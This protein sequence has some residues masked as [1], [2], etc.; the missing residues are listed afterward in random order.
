MKNKILLIALILLAFLSCKKDDPGPSYSLDK[1]EL[2]LVS[3]GTSQL[4]VMGAT[5]EVFTYTSENELIASVS[6]SGL[7]TGKRVGETFIRASFNDY[8][9]SCKVSVMPI[10]NTFVEPI[11]EF[12]ISKSEIKSKEKRILYTESATIAIFEGGRE[13]KY[14]AYFF[15]NNKLTSSAAILSSAYSSALGSYMAERYVIVSL[16]PVFGYSV[17][18]KFTV[19][20]SLT[21]DLDWF[22]FYMPNTTK[23]AKINSQSSDAIRKFSELLTK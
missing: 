17:D 10:Y 5:T 14:V 16:S 6:S 4:G 12:G 18:N 9:D 13:E 23:S 21:D 3:K 1:D 7:I 2:V 8:K 20:T 22:V 11:T 15:E 19:G